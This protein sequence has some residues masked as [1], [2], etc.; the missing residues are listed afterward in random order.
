MKYCLLLSLVYLLLLFLWL[1]AFVIGAGHGSNPFQFV[2]YLMYPARL[3]LGLLP[4]SSWPLL[5][6]FGL[7]GLIQWALIG[8]LIDRVMAHRRKKNLRQKRVSANNQTGE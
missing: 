3:L 8:Y 6:E 1:V 4:D 7:A 2:L 5:L